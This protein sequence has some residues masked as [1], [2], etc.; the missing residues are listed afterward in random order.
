MVCKITST[1][2]QSAFTAVELLIASAIGAVVLTAFMLVFWFSNRTFASLTNYMDLDQSTQIALDKMSR[3]IRQVNSL[4]AYTSNRLTFQDYDGL[5][6]QYTYDP[7]AR[8]L[9]RT[10]A[11]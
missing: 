6:L 1:K 9:T 11:A 7:S 5:T 3:E 10:K 4:T 2:G 8:K